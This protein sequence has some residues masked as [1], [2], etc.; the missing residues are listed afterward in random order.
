MRARVPK[1][2]IAQIQYTGAS[3]AYW[4]ASVATEIIAAPSAQIGSV[5]VYAAHDDI[6]EAMAKLG[7]KRTYVSAGSGKVDGNETEPL[8]EQ[9]LARI[10]L[11]VEDAY[12]RFVGDV[13]HGRGAGMTAGRVK[14]EWKGLVYSADEAQ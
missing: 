14:K 10:T 13:V 12:A 1:P 3:A 7:V 8:S 4:L 5:G 6:S 2:I 9:G 11:A